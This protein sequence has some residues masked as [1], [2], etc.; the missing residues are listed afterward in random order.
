LTEC[1]VIYGIKDETFN[2]LGVEPSVADETALHTPQ[3]NY[4]LGYCIKYELDNT[5]GRNS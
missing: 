3:Y 4:E 2:N 5:A 1:I